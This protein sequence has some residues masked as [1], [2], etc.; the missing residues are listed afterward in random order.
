MKKEKEKKN[1]WE[2]YST[3]MLKQ[4]LKKEMKELR[5]VIRNNDGIVLSDSSLIILLMSYYKK[6]KEL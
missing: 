6:S 4:E 2:S 5:E 3:I 1:Y